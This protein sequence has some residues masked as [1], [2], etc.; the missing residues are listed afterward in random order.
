MP[1]PESCHEQKHVDST[2]D[3]D[4]QATIMNDESTTNIDDLMSEDEDEHI[5]IVASPRQAQIVEPSRKKMK[6][7]KCQK[8]HSSQQKKAN[9]NNYN[10]NNM[11]PNTSVVQPQNPSTLISNLE[12]QHPWLRTQD[13]KAGTV[14]NFVILLHRVAACKRI[15]ES[16]GCVPI[17]RLTGIGSS[18][19]LNNYRKLR[20]AI[21]KLN[22]KRQ[23]DGYDVVEAS[24]DITLEL[25]RWCMDRFAM[26]KTQMISSVTKPGSYWPKEGEDGITKEQVDA[27]DVLMRSRHKIY[28]SW[29]QLN[30]KK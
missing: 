19:T 11:F 23:Q 10:N 14:S 26:T 22:Q 28:K 17:G 30:K 1:R 25:D 4:Q 7:T 15:D 3:T 13:F 2:S 24:V 5:K 21:S 18:T 20:I 16:L 6:L 27:Q 29:K 12:Q 9:M 8:F